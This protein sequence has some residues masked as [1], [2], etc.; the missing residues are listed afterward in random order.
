MAAQPLLSYRPISNAMTRCRHSSGRVYRR[1]LRHW[2]RWLCRGHELGR[3]QSYRLER[4]RTLRHIG[5]Q[6]V[7]AVM[8]SRSR[9]QA[10]LLTTAWIRASEARVVSSSSPPIDKPRTPML[11]ESMS[12]CWLMKVGAG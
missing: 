3:P 11:C 9:L 5:S 12:G 2:H 4:R 7:N 1:S 6:S 8:S 10:P